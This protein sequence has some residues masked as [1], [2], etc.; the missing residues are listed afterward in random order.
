M[1]GA[2]YVTA[3]DR[4]FL[5]DVLRHT[6][7]G[8]LTE[9][10]GLERDPGDST[11]LG[12]AGPDRRSSSPLR[13]SRCPRRWGP[14]ARRRSTD[15]EQLRRRH[16]RL[17]RHDPGRPGAAAGRVPGARHRPAG[18]DA[19]RLGRGRHLPDRSVHRVRR[20][21]APAGRGA[22]DGD[23]P[24]RAAAAARRSTTICG[25][26]PTPRPWSPWPSASARTP[27]GRINPRSEAMIDPG[28]LVARDAQTGGPVKPA[29][30]R[31]S[32]RSARRRGRCRRGRS[33]L[34]ADGLHLPHMESNAVLVDAKRSGTGQALA[35]MG[36]Q[37][38]YYTPEIFLEY[39]LHA[40]GIDESGVSLPGLEPV[41]A[42]RPRD[43]LRLDRNLG[44]LRQRGRVRR[45]ALQPRRLQADASRRRHY[46]YH[47]RCVAF[48]THDVVE[49]TPV[50]PTSP[51]RRRRRSPC[52]RSARCTA[53]SRASP[54]STA[55]RSRWR[56]RRPR[57][58]TRPRATSPSCAWPRTCPPRRR[59]SSR[60]C[61]PT[62]AARTGSTS[63]DTHIAVLQS[64]WFPR[65][66]PRAA[67]P[68]LPIWGTGQW[69][70][71]GF[72]PPTTATADCPPAPTRPRSTRRPGY[73]V[74]WNN[75]IAHGW[76]VAAGDWESG[77][78]VR[79][80]ILQDLLGR[81]LRHGP[82]DLAGDHRRG[83]RA[84]ADRR[85]ARAG[86]LAVAAP[87]DRPQPRRPRP[88]AGRDARRAGP[89][90]GSQRRST[91][92]A[93]TSSTTAPRCC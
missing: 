61:A 67:I 42:D 79:A 73:L 60:R 43:R 91:H 48:A 31:A 13:C 57:A 11:Q 30:A 24:A 15:I 47:G 36:P 86:R 3:E 93:P 54:P 2:G 9:L 40:P 63:T 88:R 23:A 41:P 66:R 53:R 87:G 12:L 70:W 16:Q 82:L 17:H 51:S 46:L 32:A 5:M 85:S 34:A 68:D 49:T 4:L 69:D 64:G 92:D 8:T 83:H 1:W 74:N 50:A 33:T 25:S 45:A 59:A 76:R 14:R 58:A 22:A 75:A 71:Q 55:R 62:P 29:A 77:P 84:V 52:T 26:P 65:P 10:L 56:S 21:A 7:Q 27:P 18:L 78:V 81:A 80:T 44:V 35:V 39:E 20:P 38:G 89:P 37:V 90:A 72:G 19:G 28:S 6:A